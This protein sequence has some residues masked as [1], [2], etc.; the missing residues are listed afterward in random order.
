MKEKTV[1]VLG[2]SEESIHFLDDALDENIRKNIVYEPEKPM[3]LITS[4]RIYC[5]THLLKG[6]KKYLERGSI[7]ISHGGEIVYP[8]MNV[9]DYATTFDPGYMD[10]DRLMRLPTT[11]FARGYLNGEFGTN[12]FTFQEAKDTIKEKKFCN[13]LYSNP[14]SHPMRDRLFH[15]I[16]KY[17]TV[18]SL[19]EHLNNTGRKTDR[20]AKNW[21]ESAVRLKKAYKFT[22]AAENGLYPG[23]TG[24]K[25]LHTFQA[26]SIPIYWGNPLIE[27]EFNPNA[28]INVHRF[29]S[30]EKLIAR[31]KEIDEDD[32]LWAEIISQPWQTEE[33]L[34]KDREG[35]SQYKAWMNHIFSQEPE[36]AIRRPLGT[37]PEIYYRKWFFSSRQSEVV[38]RGVNKIKRIIKNSG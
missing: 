34:K 12:K 21:E 31:I 26:H 37:W 18:D 19:G 9:F 27:E 4:E 20:R 8:D 11:Y 1:A 13:F 32:D 15:E 2:G 5:Y 36:E 17:K 30:F 23:A 10:G 38:S 35:V 25:I 16:S 14:F 7:L 33:Q 22:I 3:F 6:L 24:E 29:D 28:M